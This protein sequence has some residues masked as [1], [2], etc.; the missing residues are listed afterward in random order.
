LWIG[1][2]E[3]VP[4]AQDWNGVRLSL[5]MP[6]TWLVHTPGLSNFREAYRFAELGLA[7]GALLA[8]SAVEWLR[9]NAAKPVLAVV[10]VLCL[11]ELGW[12]GNPP[13]TVMPSALRIGTM[14]TSYPKI[15]RA[16]AADHSSSIV[17]DFP[18][19]IRG[20]PPVYGP[21]F[22]PQAQVLATAD[23]HPL[24]DGLISR[25]PNATINGI[26]NHPFYAGL[27]AVWHTPKKVLATSAFPQAA[28]DARQMNVGWVI[29]W[30]SNVARTIAHYL[31]LTGFKLAYRVRGVTVYHR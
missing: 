8:A 22:A 4:F 10:L 9:A 3:Y 7:G 28:R 25:V 5:L 24:A 18:F 14:A 19:G 1:A 12:S 29:V 27:V 26:K 30:P 17:V 11:L 2:K 6:F 31:E 15:D 23:G 21:A 16:I 13:G 20:G